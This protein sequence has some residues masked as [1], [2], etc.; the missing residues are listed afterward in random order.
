MSIYNNRAPFDFNFIEEMEIYNDKALSLRPV[1]EHT[2]K[3]L[4]S[5]NLPQ[6]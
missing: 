1:D 4:N 2:S 3:L 6:K 5:G